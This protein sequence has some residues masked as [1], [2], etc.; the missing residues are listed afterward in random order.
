MSIGVMYLLGVSAIGAL[1][2]LNRVA[3]ASRCFNGAETL[4][5]NQIDR[6]LSQPYPEQGP[7]PVELTP[8]TTTQTNVPVYTDP[9][10]SSVI[11]RGTVATTVTDLSRVIVANTPASPLFKVVVTVSYTLA[12]KPESV[13]I[14]TVRGMD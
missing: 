2:S 13:T 11:V 9:A 1:L 3:V 8:G 10:S 4:A 12:N 5:Q 7:A 6:V 14:S